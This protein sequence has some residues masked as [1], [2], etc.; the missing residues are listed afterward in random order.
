MFFKASSII[1]RLELEKSS[2]HIFLIILVLATKIL[3]SNG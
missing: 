1:G 2:Q 3:G